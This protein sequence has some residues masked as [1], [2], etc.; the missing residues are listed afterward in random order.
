MGIPILTQ[1]HYITTDQLLDLLCLSHC[2]LPDRSIYWRA[3][4]QEVLCDVT[5]VDRDD[6]P[7]RTDWQVGKIA[8]KCHTFTEY[9]HKAL[10]KL[11]LTHVEVRVNWSCDQSCD[12]TSVTQ[13]QPQ[14]MSLVDSISLFSKLV[15]KIC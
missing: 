2:Q 6:W 8:A 1:T 11:R 13:K 5:G 14:A 3:L 9:V 15:C 7:A 12:H 4:L 10:Q